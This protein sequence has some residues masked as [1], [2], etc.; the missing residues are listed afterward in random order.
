MEWPRG[1]NTGAK[2]TARDGVTQQRSASGGEFAALR[3][4]L[5]GFDP[6][7]VFPVREAICTD[8]ALE[9]SSHFLDVIFVATQ[10]IK[11]AFKDDLFAAVDSTKSGRT[12]TWTSKRSNEN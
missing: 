12:G 4:H 11:I 3:D 1:L 10:G 8:A 2:A 5:E 9:T 7:A 6:V